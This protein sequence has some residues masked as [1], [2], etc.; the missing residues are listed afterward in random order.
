MRAPSTPSRELEI[1]GE[2][3]RR[4]PEDHRQVEG[5]DLRFRFADG[6]EGAKVDGLVG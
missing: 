5:A 1:A 6:A 2:A 3:L 4:R